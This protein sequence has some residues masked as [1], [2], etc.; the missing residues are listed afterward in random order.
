MITALTTIL[1]DLSSLAY[2]RKT[3]SFLLGRQIIRPHGVQ[4]LF[5]GVFGEE[6]DSDEEAPLDKLE[7]IARLLRSIPKGFPEEV[8]NLEIC[9]ITFTS[10]VF[11]DYYRII[12]SQ[13]LSILSSTE[14]TMPTTYKRAAAFTISTLLSQ[15]DSPTSSRILLPS[16]HK[17]FIH[18]TQATSRRSHDDELT[19]LKSLQAIQSLLVNTDPSPNLISR[20][21]TPIIPPLYALSGTLDEH[22]TS[23]PALKA[24]VH[25]LLNTWGRLIG[26]E[27]G[28]ACIWLIVEGE[29][30]YWKVNITGEVT[31]VEKRYYPICHSIERENA[32]MRCPV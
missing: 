23:D 19:A 4:G 29:G 12:T 31:K 26:T 3:C 13:L 6:E 8:R 28:S 32:N 5:L 27:E 17:P 10:I 22:R 18:V 9:A 14:S 15:K 21:L 2:V 1:S 24:S 11:Q 16:L 20:L 30:G 7:Q 25:G